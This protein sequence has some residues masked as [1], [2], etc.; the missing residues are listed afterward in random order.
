MRTSETLYYKTTGQLG[1]HIDT[2]SVYSISVALSEEE[3]YHTE[4]S[5][6]SRPTMASIRICHVNCGVMVCKC[7]L[8]IPGRRYRLPDEDYL[9]PSVRRHP[10]SKQLI[11]EHTTCK[12]PPSTFITLTRLLYSAGCFAS[13]INTRRVLVSLLSTTFYAICI[14][15][16]LCFMFDSGCNSKASGTSSYNSTSS[17]RNTLKLLDLR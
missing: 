15:F 16:P 3:D 4:A 12:H 10:A 9:A 5:S 13:L 8:I 1:T 17:R 11:Q 7:P 14:N 2:D 6:V